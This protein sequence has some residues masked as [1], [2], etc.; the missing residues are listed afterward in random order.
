MAL[1]DISRRAL[2]ESGRVRVDMP[3]NVRLCSVSAPCF[4][5]LC[6]AAFA[7]DT[8]S[9]HRSDTGYDYYDIGRTFIGSAELN[10]FGS[11][12]FFDSHQS[13]FSRG[14]I[15][16]TGGLEFEDS[17][18]CVFKRDFPDYSGGSFIVDANYRIVNY[19]SLDYSSGFYQY[20]SA[21]ETT[22]SSDAMRRTVIPKPEND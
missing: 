20:N 17:N 10:G 15:V 6:S 16:S 7:E 9:V 12:D 4:I 2:R 22:A 8:I 11:Y 19:T 5:C 14:K 13:F 21:G 3:L 1:T 18:G